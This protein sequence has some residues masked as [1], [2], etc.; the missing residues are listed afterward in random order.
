[1]LESNNPKATYTKLC[2]FLQRASVVLILKGS[3]IEKRLRT[4]EIA[5][6]S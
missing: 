4:T 2:I 3:M 1:M 6:S 5:I